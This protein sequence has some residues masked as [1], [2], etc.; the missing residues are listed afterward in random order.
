[1]SFTVLLNMNYMIDHILHCIAIGEGWKC[2]RWILNYCED[3]A[4]GLLEIIFS[5]GFRESELF[6]NV[7]Q[8]ISDTGDTSFGNVALFAYIMVKQ[9][10]DIPSWCAVMAPWC[11]IVRFI[12]DN[13]TSSRRCHGVLIKIVWAI[14]VCIYG[15]SWVESGVA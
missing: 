8:C 10:A 6:W 2:L 4:N 13:H 11:K 12:M 1:M 15:E 5:H 9:W 3:V 14:K 7:L